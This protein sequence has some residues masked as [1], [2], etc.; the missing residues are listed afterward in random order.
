MNGEA[1]S[2]RGVPTSSDRPGR[3]FSQVHVFRPVGFGPAGARG[4]LGYIWP[5][6][7]TPRRDLSPGV[8]HNARGMV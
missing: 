4:C 6:N 7:Q 1:G 5:R 3:R 2:F 8:R